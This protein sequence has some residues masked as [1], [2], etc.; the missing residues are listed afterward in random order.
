V[1]I[2]KVRPDQAEI[3][4]SGAE[5]AVAVWTGAMQCDRLTNVVDRKVIAPHLK[6]DDAQQMQSVGMGGTTG[7]KA[8]ISGLGLLQ[9]VGSMVE[10]AASK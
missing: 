1:R 3:A 10:E 8:A 7:Q 5:I 6:G 9:P 4:Q 2:A